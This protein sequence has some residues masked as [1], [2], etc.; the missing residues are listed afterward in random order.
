M[1]FLLYLSFL[2]LLLLLINKFLVK[3]NILI[4]ETGDK[5]QKFASKEKVPLTGG[6]F[7]FLSFLFFFNDQ[8]LSFILF[9]FLIFSLGIFSDLKKI[10]SALFRFFIQITLVLSFVIFN[11]L[12]RVF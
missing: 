6:I 7:L 10:E 11:D 2:T 12:A 5:H 1:N 4:S 8:I 9:S 3:N